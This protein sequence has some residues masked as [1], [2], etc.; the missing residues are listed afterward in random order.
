MKLSN[1]LHIAATCRNYLQIT[2]S[3]S[4]LMNRL[5][6]LTSCFKTWAWL[7]HRSTQR[8]TN[9]TPNTEQYPAEQITIHA[10]FIV[11]LVF[12]VFPTVTK[13][14]RSVMFFSNKKNLLVTMDKYLSLNKFKN[15]RTTSQ[16]CYISIL[17][18]I[19]KFNTT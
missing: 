1:A 12:R 7:T 10:Y 5:S 17:L 18:T 15:K 13:I 2:S 3:F 19:V 16:E 9:P 14:L 8:G 4:L 11:P 6:L